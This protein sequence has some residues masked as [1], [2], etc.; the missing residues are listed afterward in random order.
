LASK[1]IGSKRNLIW[2]NM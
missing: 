1:R 2:I